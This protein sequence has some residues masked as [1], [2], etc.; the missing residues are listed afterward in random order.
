MQSKFHLI[1]TDDEFEDEYRYGAFKTCS[2][3]PDFASFPQ[4]STLNKSSRK[5]DFKFDQTISSEILSKDVDSSSCK[6]IS[7]NSQNYF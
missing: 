5:I 6:I 2:A 1:E 7:S 3:R 4:N